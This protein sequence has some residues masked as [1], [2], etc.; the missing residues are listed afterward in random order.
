MPMST[1]DNTTQENLSRLRGVV[2]S[3]D[4]QT[5]PEPC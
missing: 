1:T 2:A 4:C 5:A 3:E